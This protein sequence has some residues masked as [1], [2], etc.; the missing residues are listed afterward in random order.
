[1]NFESCVSVDWYHLAQ[2]RLSVEVMI[3]LVPIWQ[4]KLEG[5]VRMRRRR[6]RKEVALLWQKY[7]IL[8]QN[9][10]KLIQVFL[11]KYLKSVFIGK[12]YLLF[13]K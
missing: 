5:T 9:I 8:S 6:I 7:Y 2:N 3:F 4:R 10:S 1:M 13:I 11:N 12:P